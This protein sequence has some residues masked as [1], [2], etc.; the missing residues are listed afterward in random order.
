LDLGVKT[1]WIMVRLGLSFKVRTWSG[2]QNMTFHWSL[3]QTWSNHL[4][5][6]YCKLLF[7]SALIRHYLQ[8][9][10]KG[11]KRDNLIFII[12]LMF[13][14]LLQR[15]TRQHNVIE[16]F[17]WQ[18]KKHEILEKCTL[19]NTPQL[20]RVKQDVHADDCSLLL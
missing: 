9:L 6:F 16:L 3:A 12:P 11:R 17:A 18:N 13:G 8:K 2:L 1:F 7:D 14:S 5:R 10:T 15:G 19:S 20:N 4:I